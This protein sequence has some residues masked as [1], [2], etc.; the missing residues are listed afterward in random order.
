MRKISVLK[1]RLKKK[2]AKWSRG[3]MRLKGEW[4]E[5]FRSKVFVLQR[6]MSF[7]ESAVLPFWHSFN[8]RQT[9]LILR[10]LTAVSLSISAMQATPCVENGL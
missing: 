4:R 8:I 1:R 7:G 9:Y 6:S 10:L 2:A 3:S 5:P